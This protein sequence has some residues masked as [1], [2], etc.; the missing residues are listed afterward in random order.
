MDSPIILTY[1]DHKGRRI[2]QLCV[3]Y[4][5]RERQNICRAELSAKVVV[6]VLAEIHWERSPLSMTRQNPYETLPSFHCLETALFQQSRVQQLL[7]RA[8]GLGLCPCG[9]NQSEHVAAETQCLPQ[10]HPPTRG[11]RTAQKGYWPKRR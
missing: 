8:L 7:G 2:S 5:K 4:F 11:P 1:I 6:L 3:I 9:Q 10:F